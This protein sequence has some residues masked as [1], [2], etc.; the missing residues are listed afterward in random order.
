[1]L[2]SARVRIVRC[3]ALGFATLALALGAAACGARTALEVGQGGTSGLEGADAAGVLNASG[4]AGAY[5]VAGVAGAP[6]AMATL[7]GTF[8][9]AICTYYTQCQREQFKDF[10]HCRAELDC[11]GVPALRDALAAGHVVLD[12]N[13]LARCFQDF[14]ASPCDPVRDESSVFND[15]LDIYQFL[16]ECP[17]VLT[18]LQDV[19]D[20]CMADAECKFRL[21]CSKASCSGVCAPRFE[22][23]EPCSPD[24]TQCAIPY[25][26]CEQGTCRILAE[27]GGSCVDDYDCFRDLL[28]DP[29]T[30]TCVETVHPGLGGD[31]IRDFNGGKPARICQP[32]L[33][34]NDQDNLGTPGICS[35]FQ[36][37]GQACNYN[38]CAPGLDCAALGGGPRVCHAKPAKGDLCDY[39]ENYCQDDLQCVPNSNDGPPPTGVCSERP[40]LGQPCMGD[41]ASGLT[42]GPGVCIESA[43]P[44]DPCEQPSGVCQNAECVNGIC[45]AYTHVG[46]P[47]ASASECLMYECL[48]GVCA[49]RTAC[50]PF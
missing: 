47:C 38:G 45:R 20:A 24:L 15:P 8:T 31:C 48:N 7:C 26:I 21:Q 41:C 39:G 37:E 50:L 32:N 36:R 5:G 11:Y 35:E 42:C 30:R 4:V 43:Y 34:C 2:R 9:D 19:G 17:G 22:L 29:S 1:M 14:Y 27:V 3:F 13:A 49:D 12:E 23:G 25:G 16:Q 46:A 40:T 10:D 28:C 44:G 33:F 18:P 6:G